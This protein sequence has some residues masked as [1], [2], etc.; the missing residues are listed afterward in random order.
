MCDVRDIKQRISK[1]TYSEQLQEP[2]QAGMEHPMDC[3]EAGHG[4]PPYAGDVVTMNERDCDPEP[5]ETEQPV[6]PA[7]YP[8]QCTAT[9]EHCDT[10]TYAI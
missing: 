3:G 10:P 5:H 6:H 7:Q 9:T 8:A 4:V 2:G 1:H